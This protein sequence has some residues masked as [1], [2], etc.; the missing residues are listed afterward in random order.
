MTTMV[1]M[2]SSEDYMTSYDPALHEADYTA[3]ISSVKRGRGRPTKEI[4][5][6][7]CGF[8]GPTEPDYGQYPF[9]AMDII[10]GIARLDWH[11]RAIGVGG[12]SKPLSV[13]RLVAIIAD[14]E[15]VS[16]ATVM[17]HSR[18]GLR[19][20]QRY[21][22]AIELAMP[23]LLKSRPD[24]LSHLMR[25]GFLKDAPQRSSQWEDQLE[26]PSPE[27]LAQLHYDLRTLGV[28]SVSD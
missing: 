3:S 4:T 5:N 16:A 27:A 7:F 6:L 23:R 14:L 19:Q 18:L 26:P 10:E 28:G 2:T 11:D 13:K 24:A 12:S 17:A 8:I 9:F 15:V 21:V 25:Y 20:A 22:K 1:A